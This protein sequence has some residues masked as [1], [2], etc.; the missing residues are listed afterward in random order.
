MLSERA[1]LCGQSLDPACHFSGNA[2][3]PKGAHT[4][5]KPSRRMAGLLFRPQKSLKKRA[6]ILINQEKLSLR[7]APELLKV[8]AKE[9]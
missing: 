6:C 4:I 2:I 8:A 7:L 3:I 5:P 1:A 9:H